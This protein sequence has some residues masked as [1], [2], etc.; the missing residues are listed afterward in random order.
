[1][2]WATE[3]SHEY[4]LFELGM[5]HF[6]G[7]NSYVK[8]IRNSIGETRLLF[9]KSSVLKG[10]PGLK[11]QHVKRYINFTY[12]NGT[13][14]KTCMGLRYPIHKLITWLFEDN[15]RR[16]FHIFL[17]FILN[18]YGTSEQQVYSTILVNWL[19]L[20]VSVRWSRL[21]TNVISDARTSS[22]TSASFDRSLRHTKYYDV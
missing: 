20:L 6:E 1:M 7:R 14:F 19:M 18:N 13:K 10:R 4:C 2:D 12:P 21:I 5:H 16:H 3:T 9:V 17:N 15:F 22:D 8:L 11:D